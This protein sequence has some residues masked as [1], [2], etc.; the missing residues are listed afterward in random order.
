MDTTKDIIKT[1][2]KGKFLKRCPGTPVYRCCNYY[3][4]NIQNNCVL[5]CHYCI[6]QD[7]I[8][9]NKVTVFTNVHDALNEV[10]T[11]TLLLLMKS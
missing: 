5:D 4:L 1:P 10:K 9:S 11:V 8:N 6:L 3:V 7:Y 2:F